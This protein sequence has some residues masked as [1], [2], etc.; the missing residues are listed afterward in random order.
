M[1]QQQTIWI[2]IAEIA[3][4]LILGITCF[5]IV[6][7]TRSGSKTLAYLLFA[8]FVPVIGIVFYFSFGVNYRKRKM[9]DRKL[10]VDEQ[11]KKEVHRLFQ[12]HNLEEAIHSDEVLLKSERL[13]K[14]LANRK[15]NRAF[16]LPNN[17]FQLLFNGE[18]KFPAL[19]A[20]LQGAKHHIHIE[21][22][23][24]ENDEI[25]NTIKE[26]L[27]AKAQQG[28][29]VRVIYDDFGS[30]GIRRNIV[31]ELKRNGAEAYPFNKVRLLL[32]AN[33]L[34]YRNHRKI[35]IIDGIVAYTGGINVSDK[36]IN[37]SRNRTYWRDTH[38]RIKG[39]GA[40]ALQQVFV[41]DWNFC[42]DEHLS[43]SGD[44]YFPFNQMEVHGQG[45]LQVISSGPDSDL[46]NILFA[47][48][49]AVHT[50][51]SEILLTT[52]YFIPDETLQQS[53]LMAAM[54]GIDVKLLVPEKGDSRIVDS[55][56]RIY[57]EELLQAGVKI[58]LYKRGFIHAKTFVVDGVLASVGTANLDL[59][60]F[61]L[62]FE[63]ST[64][65]YDTQIAE[66]LRN[67]FYEDLKHSE[68]LFYTRWIKRS[69]W[70]KGLE[71]VLRLVSPF[72]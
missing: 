71:R 14:L 53:L 3:Y 49:Q 38:L 40:M 72:M 15:S 68:Q 18:E 45:K 44:Q 63:V 34:N 30:K 6:Y 29:K 4:L 21:Y 64:L 56:S 36:Y 8:I 54:G 47:T 66:Q 27:I 33:R 22:Y 11:F 39:T 23:I 57:F 51:K 43:V 26:I 16:L 61:D 13:I 5:R 37:A 17:N 55:V 12:A 65:I 25:G 58:Y 67:A 52:P 50:A 42:S 19:I 70:I 48:L 28:V 1:L 31:R 59:R 10:N 24:Y 7:D 46:P 2:L 41:S 20:D 62:N 9:Y 60:S 32:L 69:L 35:V